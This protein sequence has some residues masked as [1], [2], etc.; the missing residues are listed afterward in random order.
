MALVVDEEDRRG[1]AV[2]GKVVRLDRRQGVT[3]ISMVF[4]G[5]GGEVRGNV[6]D[7]DRSH[8]VDLGEGLD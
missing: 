7:D 1:R 8:S 5:A 2:A 3:E 4:I 6:D